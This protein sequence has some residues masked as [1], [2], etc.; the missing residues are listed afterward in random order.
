[1]SEK[2]DERRTKGRRSGA[3]RVQVDKEECKERQE[4][5]RDE[6]NEVGGERK[7]REEGKTDRKW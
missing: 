1:M 3:D 4:V 6:W 2:M 7:W 5:R